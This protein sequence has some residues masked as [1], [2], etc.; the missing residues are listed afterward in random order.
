[1]VKTKI[2]VNNGYIESI[3]KSNCLEIFSDN[4]Q[5]LFPDC[6]LLPGLSESH[7]HV[8]GLGMINSGMDVSGGDSEEATLRIAK[9]N[10]FRKGNWSTGRGWNNELWQNPLPPSRELADKYFPDNPIALTRVDGHS[11]WCNSKALEIAGINSNT[12]VP[13]GGIII[14]DDEGSPNGLL[15]DNAM[16][17]LDEF[18]PDFTENQLRKFILKGLNICLNAGLTAVHDM[19]VS[20]K[21][22]DIYHKLNCENKLPIRVFAYVG[23]QNDEAFNSKIMP[24]K[25]EMFS[26]QG[27]KLF[28]DGALGSYGAALLDDYSDKAGEKGLIILNALSI[29]KKMVKASD[30][31]FDIAIHAIGDAAN[32][33]VLDAIEMFRNERPQSNSIV[34][35]EHAQTVHPDD[36]QRFKQLNVVASVQPIHFVSDA[37]M[38]YKRLGDSRLVK[39][40][41]LWKSFEDA[42]VCLVGGSDFPI[43]SH[44]PFIGINDF[45]HR[46]NELTNSRELAK[47]RLSL[48][49]AI[50]CYSSNPYKALNVSNNGSIKVGNKADFTI[51]KSNTL[52]EN[53]ELV[54]T[55]INGKKLL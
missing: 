27:I 10:D 1:M 20:P 43:E 55:F 8:W 45:V 11:I 51:I 15:V 37:K 39:S 23:C 18:I 22:I 30:L 42:G 41:Y 50:D 17:I 44:N 4:Q 31:G 33:E 14:K 7:C 24:F 19:D 21:M 16:N 29:L 35:I 36:L 54:S 32:R 25:S 9:R 38:A 12:T 26:I 48:E 47:E 52:S 2:I 34:R 49:S 40:G 53:T 5:F 46:F 13:N 28:A 6:E 3:V